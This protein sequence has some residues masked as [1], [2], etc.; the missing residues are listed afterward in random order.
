LTLF[1]LFP[2]LG[3]FFL[4][5]LECVVGFSHWTPL[6]WL[7]LY[8]TFERS[9]SQQKVYGLRRLACALLAEAGFG[10]KSSSKLPHSIVL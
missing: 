7:R 1:F 4:S 8:S 6:I 10:C 9:I 5:L 2:L 3:E